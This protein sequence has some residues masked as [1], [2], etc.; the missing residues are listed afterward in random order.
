MRPYLRGCNSQKSRRALVH[1]KMQS[2][3]YCQDAFVD[4]LVELG[5]Q[6][7]QDRHWLVMSNSLLLVFRF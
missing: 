3:C 1:S 4:E 2:A 6:A 5:I 7:L